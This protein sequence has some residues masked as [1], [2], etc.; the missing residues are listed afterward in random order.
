MGLSPRAAWVFR[1]VPRGVIGVVQR[2]V[3]GVVQ[4]GVSES[5]KEAKSG[6]FAHPL[7]VSKTPMEAH[8]SKLSQPASIQSNDIRPVLHDHLRKQK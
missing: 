4:R 3:I 2:G 7:I 6:Y 1:L 8:V 5:G